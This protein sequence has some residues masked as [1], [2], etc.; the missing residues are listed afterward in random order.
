[1][2]NH[3]VYLA[4]A[5]GIEVHV[6]S[7]KREGS[8]GLVRYIRGNAKDDGFLMQILARRWDVIV[9][10]MIYDTASFERRIERLLEATDQYVFL[11]S[12]RVYA[13]ST[14]PMA[15]TAPRL[16][17]AIRDDVFLATDDYA[18]AKARQEDIMQRSGRKNWTI[19]RPYITY[20]RERLQLGALEKEGWLYRALHGRAIL[21]P[22]EI[23]DRFTT[24]TS[25]TNV[26]QAMV[27]LLG[28]NEA[29]G[30]AY[31]VTSAQICQWK[32][33]LDVYLDVIEERL[34]RRPRVVMV[35]TADYLHCHRANYQL[36]Y[37]RLY[38]RR[39]DNRKISAFIDVSTF[40]TVEEGLRECLASFLT[41]P[42]FKAIDWRSE[43][44]KDRLVQE[45]TPFREIPGLENK[46]RYLLYRYPKK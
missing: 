20:A 21:F 4:A 25:A 31:H 27:A 26:A 3:L 39:F 23:A 6:T 34:G 9:D 13:G 24:L 37:D 17:D 42:V 36:R 28:R 43:A 45:R 11:S 1:M 2:G 14:A 5:Q 44:R 18:L 10:F 30:Q 40:V 33:V 15:E 19:F 8:T 29:L 38:D 7:R 22:E 41:L 16:L 46:L 32:Y 35:E 12:G